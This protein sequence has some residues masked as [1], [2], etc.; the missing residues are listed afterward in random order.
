MQKTD[1]NTK[2]LRG[3]ARADQVTKDYTLDDDDAL[4]WKGKL[5]IPPD[6]ALV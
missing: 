6:A 3:S 4:R 5:V 2:A 1:A